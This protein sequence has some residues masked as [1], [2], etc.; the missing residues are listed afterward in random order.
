MPLNAN[1]M[2][3]ACSAH[4]V[5][6]IT[7]T[8]S[9]YLSRKLLSIF[10]H[11][12]WQF[13][14]C[15]WLSKAKREAK[16]KR[17]GSSRELQFLWVYSLLYIYFIFI[18]LLLILFFLLYLCF[19]NLREMIYSYSK[20]CCCCCCCWHRSSIRSLTDCLTDWMRVVV[21][22]FP[23]PP[24]PPLT[25]WFAFATHA[26]SISHGIKLFLLL[27]LLQPHLVLCSTT[28]AHTEK[29]RERG[30]ERQRERDR[31]RCALPSFALQW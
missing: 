22:S 9:T 26:P 28:V 20:L 18:S 23:L 25:Q 30:I 5:K 2:V 24:A 6:S 8:W 15:C 21:A 14:L 1:W 4:P 7:L 27:L 19:G 3:I 17:K 16:K 29:K 31:V 13:S 11:S 10:S 12:S